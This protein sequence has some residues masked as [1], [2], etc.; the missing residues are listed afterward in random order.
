MPKF[1]V[2]VLF[3]LSLSISFFAL[4][5]PSFAQALEPHTHEG[6][7]HSHPVKKHSHPARPHLHE[8]L[9]QIRLW[10]DSIARDTER[11]PITGEE[12]VDGEKVY[13]L[14]TLR[15]T[16]LS[17]GLTFI[18]QGGLNN[19]KQFGGDR[20]DGSFS[21]DLILE[22]E[23]RNNGLMIIRGDFMRGDG[24][25]RLPNLFSGGVNADIEDLKQDNTFKN[26]PGTFNLIEALYEQ[27]WE[28]ERYRL[29]FGQMDPTSYFDQNAFANSETF[30]FL[31]PMF[32]NNIAIRFGGDANGY[33][34]GL[35]LHAHPVKA[36]ELNVG[37]FEGNGE[38]DDMMDQPFWIIEAEIESYRGDL[39]GHYRFIYWSNETNQVKLL[40]A[41]AS[42]S[43][44]TGFAISFDQ[45]VT[46]QVGFWAR[47]GTQEGAVSQF[48]YSASI[49]FQL[50]GLLGRDDASFGLA[51]G[52]TFI[53]DEYA[54]SAGLSEDEHVI[55]AYY[56]MD[57]GHGFHLAPDVQY[58][59][60]PGGDGA[61]DPITV[62]GIRAQLNF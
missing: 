62:Y 23:I 21:L 11:R 42:L 43:R 55:E 34:P 61:I 53:S 3:F 57:A 22:S 8:E 18:A 50:K 33:G 49:G 17:G 26:N 7:E 37:F 58:I 47:F 52:K 24:L 39:E 60:N 19:E 38:Y 14:Q 1:F 10:L 6:D 16:R 51:Y 46:R 29:S 5:S 15:K 32:V 59:E 25:T 36:F 12:A 35:V 20:A 2:A 9:Q 41:N 40:D 31:S 48:D 13:P 28:D 27:T 56:N 54:Q 44:N 30:Q 4:P 45:E